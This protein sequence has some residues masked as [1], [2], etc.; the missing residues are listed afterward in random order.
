MAHQTSY[1]RVDV[2]VSWEIR[3][4]DGTGDNGAH[5]GFL[6]R[7]QSRQPGGSPARMRNTRCQSH[8]MCM[9]TPGQPSSIEISLSMSVSGDDHEFTSCERRCSATRFGYVIAF[10]GTSPMITPLRNVLAGD[11]FHISA[12]RGHRTPIQP[13]PEEQSWILDIHYLVPDTTVSLCS[14]RCSSLLPLSPNVSLTWLSFI[15][16]SNPVVYSTP[17]PQ[18]CGAWDSTRAW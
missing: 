12:Q 13:L 16:E 6:S 18:V 3:R 10:S 8:P 9:I 2:D 11:I 5:D 15:D 14:G 4:S 7:T 17:Y 1:T